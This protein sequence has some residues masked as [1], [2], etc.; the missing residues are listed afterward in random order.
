M[1]EFVHLHVHTEYSL[2]DGICRIEPLVEAAAALGQRALAITDHG[3]LF[4]AV[5]FY[6]ACRERGVKPILGCE[7]YLAPDPAAGLGGAAGTPPVSGPG[8]AT[9]APEP[10][11]LVL[12]AENLTGYRNLMRLVS[13]PHLE[14]RPGLPAVTLADLEA[15]REG[16]IALSGCLR[17]PLARPLREGRAEEARRWAVRLREI[18][19]PDR[20]FVELQDHGWEEER[21]VGRAL[22]AL[23]RAL[24]LQLVATN[25]VHYLT[26]G[27]ARLHDLVLAIGSGR[28]LQ[29][30]HRLRFPTDQYYLKSGAEMAARFAELPEALA[31]TAAIA[32]RCEVELPLGRALLPAYPLPPGWSD[33]DAYLRHLCTEALPRR[34]PQGAGP[35]VRERLEHELSIIRSMGFAEYFLIVWDFV[36]AARERGILVGPGRGSG[37][38]SLVAYL[39]GITGVDPLAHGLLFERF[40][41]PERVDLPDL[42]IDF[43]HERRDEVIAYV[44]EKYGRDRVAQIITFGTMAAR[45]AVRDVGRALGLPPGEVDRVARAIPFGMDLATARQQVPELQQAAGRRELAELLDLAEALEGLPRHASTHAA[46]VVIAPG[47]L[48][49]YVPLYRGADGTLVTQ[50]DM[51]GLQAIGLLKMDFLGL[52][53]LTVIDRAVQ[54]IRAREP[55]FRL[56]AIPL[57]DPA[58]YA[59]L[60]AGQTLGVFQLEAG[61]V[62]DVLRQ[63]RPARFQDVVAVISLCRP[64]PMQYIP[65][66]IARRETGPRYPH[67]DLADILQET[68]GIMVYQEQVMQVAARMAG[69]SLGQADLLRRAVGK[70]KREELERYRDAFIAGAVARGYDRA[71]AEQVYADILRF[72][73]Y[74]FNKSHAVA[75]GLLAYQTAY[76]KRHYPVEFMAALLNSVMGS[77]EKVNTYVAEC[78]RLGIPVLP[79]DILTGEAGFTPAYE[80]GRPVGIRFGLAA[81]K[82]VGAGAVAEIQA[83]RARGPIRSLTDLL[84]RTEGRYLSRRALEALIKAGACDSLGVPRAQLLAELDRALEEAQARGRLARGGQISLFDLPAG[85]QA[86]VGEEERKAGSRGRPVK[87]PVLY[88]RV[89]ARDLDDE[90]V[91]RIRAILSRFPGSTRV[92]IKLEPQGRWIEVAEAYRVRLTDG[93]LEALRDLLGP[94]GVVVR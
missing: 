69:F 85:P 47:P 25:D 12:L 1:T 33:P 24:G 66:Y 68:Y 62:A 36:R 72:A 54:A 31:A 2:L 71:L 8:P 87:E 49:D 65:E 44:A 76:L 70:K 84:T 55:G 27:E 53:T 16:L 38:G 83:A 6:Q 30:P 52:R 51:E 5:R 64:G 82:H 61:W 73:S 18:F 80:G 19:G 29:D 42:D 79:P 88:L 92:R 10:F 34:Y 89:R 14:G 59:M 4:G 20:F 39:L 13:R 58:T 43:D 78:R 90:P 74:G 3:A 11:H 60:A 28:T 23:A 17:G 37:A 35:E 22:V 9:G 94:D 32:E 75:Y 56:E 26:P 7:V 77:E 46:G 45:A 81:I 67:P 63:L 41:N 86:P 91:R 48:T 21:R 50:Y 40:L 93:L 57:D 15:H